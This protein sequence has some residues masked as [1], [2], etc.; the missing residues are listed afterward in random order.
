MY[1]QILII[2]IIFIILL[3]I[4]YKSI[5]F[6]HKMEYSSDTDYSFP[7]D[8]S[9]STEFDESLLDGG[10]RFPIP[11]INKYRT[12]FIDSVLN[13]IAN[14]D[15]LTKHFKNIL[16]ESKVSDEQ[17][18][19]A[20]TNGLKNK[21]IISSLIE[22]NDKPKNNRHR[23][24][25][26]LCCLFM[27]GTDDNKYPKAVLQYI[28]LYLLYL[29]RMSDFNFHFEQTKKMYAGKSF[30]EYVCAADYNYI[31]YFNYCRE[32]YKLGKQPIPYTGVFNNKLIRNLELCNKLCSCD[33]SEI[34]DT[35]NITN[36]S[37][38]FIEIDNN[39]SCYDQ[40]EQLNMFSTC[41][42][43]YDG[44]YRCTD[45][46][47]DLYEKDNEDEPCHSVYYNID[48]GILHDDGELIKTDISN[49]SKQFDN[50]DYYVPCILHFQYN[51]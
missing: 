16:P 28:R 24:Y 40:N 19:N 32:S 37:D 30:Y 49:I 3:Y 22:K 35:L 2:I 25:A 6:N 18:Q 9:F 34:Q 23:L 11:T 10:L 44:K 47:L 15:T 7:S 17:I 4:L 8:V 42:K 33:C 26:I 39:M 38:V 13:S 27:R 1:I 14:S 46:I 41:T 31:L 48:K 5:L 45:I 50:G 20:F 12:C 43:P 51:L 29:E 21:T 36:K